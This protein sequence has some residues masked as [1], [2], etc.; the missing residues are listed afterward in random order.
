MLR[1]AISKMYQRLAGKS[2]RKKQ[3]VMGYVTYGWV[4][5][6]GKKTTRPTDSSQS[7]AP[8]Y[9]IMDQKKSIDKPISLHFLALP[10]KWN[11][12]FQPFADTC[13]EMRPN[14]GEIRKA[15]SSS[16]PCDLHT[17][18]AA[19]FPIFTGFT[20]SVYR[21][22]K[23][24]TTPTHLPFTLQTPT[25]PTTQNPSPFDPSL[26]KNQSTN[27]LLNLCFTIRTITPKR[28]VALTAYPKRG[29]RKSQG[30]AGIRA[31]KDRN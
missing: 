28:S 23:D 31:V 30:P 17:I 3:A 8:W 26:A 1:A 7:S 14:R 11:H 13:P 9:A 21:R 2:S 6:V 10:W 5:F 18:T 4:T 22:W 19:F 24:I 27:L 16:N 15:P 20:V 25:P 29:R 12:L